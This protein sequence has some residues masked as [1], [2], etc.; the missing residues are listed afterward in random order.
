MLS[1]DCT[2]R[3]IGTGER[4]TRAVP[5]G[6]QPHE[7]FADCG[8]AEVAQLGPCNQYLVLLSGFS[9]LSSILACY[10]VLCFASLAS[11]PGRSA[12][13]HWSGFFWQGRTLLARAWGRVTRM[14]AGV[15]TFVS[16]SLSLLL[17]GAS[18]IYPLLFLKH[19]HALIQ[20]AVGEELWLSHA[21]TR[22]WIKKN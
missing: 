12:A 18:L 8:T 4:E 9:C 16:A 7:E 1:S 19:G 21:G 6:M 20:A 11:L 10:L 22:S 13:V 5:F 2:E 17:S 3:R 14:S 15:P